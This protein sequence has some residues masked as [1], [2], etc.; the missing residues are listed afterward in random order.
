MAP[1]HPH[2]FCTALHIPEPYYLM[3]SDKQRRCNNSCIRVLLSN[4]RRQVSCSISI[5]VILLL[6][7]I[8]HNN[9]YETGHV[10]S[11]SHQQLRGVESKVE[12]Q[13]RQRIVALERKNIKLSALYTA[14][15]AQLD[16]KETKQVVSSSVSGVPLKVRTR[17]RS[18]TKRQQAVVSSFRWAWEGYKKSA[19][20]KDELLPVSQSSHEWFG[21]GLTM[22]WYATERNCNVILHST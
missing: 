17:E 8:S 1:T 10:V 5:C 20:G 9:H 4:R 22:V 16:R 11:G 7:V 18:L 13:L 2:H 15:Q 6:A 14:P 3:G 19:W 21:L 12:V